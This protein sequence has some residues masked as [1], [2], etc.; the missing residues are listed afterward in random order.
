MLRFRA[1]GRGLGSA[2][3][4]FRVSICRFR[5]LGLVEGLALTGLR[6]EAE[7]KHRPGLEAPNSLVKPKTLLFHKQNQ[8][9]HSV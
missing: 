8:Q 9:S 6:L 5:L 2:A 7:E 1:S 4:R 3:L